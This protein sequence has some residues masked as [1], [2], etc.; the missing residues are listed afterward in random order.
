MISL[1]PWNVQFMVKK[2]LSNDDVI[3]WKHFPRYWPFVRRIHRSQVNSPHKGQWRGALM[4]SLR[5]ALSKQWW[6]W[7]FDTQF[8]P[9]WRYSN[10]MC[11][12]LVLLGYNLTSTIVICLPVLSFI[13]HIS[14]LFKMYFSRILQAKGKTKYMANLDISAD[15]ILCMHPVNGRR[16]CIVTSSLIGWVHTKKSLYQ[17]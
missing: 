16:R 8:G 11:K 4:F 15:I 12:K 14:C 17:D 1:F 7:W 3:K 9:L 5:C 13:N 10:V 2:R 6:C